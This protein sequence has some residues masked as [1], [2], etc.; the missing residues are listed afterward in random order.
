MLI[1]AAE[2]LSKG[3]KFVRVDLY[4]IENQLLVGEMTFWPGAGVYEGEG[5]RFLGQMLDFDRTTFQPNI[6]SRLPATHWGAKH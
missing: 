3:W 6:L 2:T 4:S 1:A 5:Q